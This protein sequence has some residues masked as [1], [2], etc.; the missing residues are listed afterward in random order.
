[1]MISTNQ[2]ECIYIRFISLLVFSL[3]FCKGKIIAI[4]LGLER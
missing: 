3:Q 4:F 1:M 2:S